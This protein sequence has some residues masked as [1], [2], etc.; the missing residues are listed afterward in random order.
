MAEEEEVVE[1]SIGEG[2]IPPDL[3]AELAELGIGPHTTRMLETYTLAQL[4]DWILA[5]WAITEQEDPEEPISTMDSYVYRNTDF[6]SETSFANGTTIGDVYG[7]Y[8]DMQ[9]YDPE[10]F[11][12]LNQSLLSNGYYGVGASETSL[13]NYSASARAFGHAVNA[14]VMTG[15]APITWGGGDLVDMQMTGKEITFEFG[16]IG[17]V[18]YVPETGGGASIIRTTEAQIGSMVDDAA[19]NVFGRKASV[20]ERR[21]AI[22][23]V[24]ALENGR[25]RFGAA[26]LEE[27]LIEAAPEEAKAR[28]MESTLRNFSNIIRQGGA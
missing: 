23:V 2:N 5:Q 21:M 7:A 28:D 19:G 17:Q 1:E 4:K 11:V 13:T 25:K 26:D 14:G 8:F 20:E 22:S 10:S 6:E 18:A 27:S 9:K 16:N 3:L 24:R 12:A 15:A